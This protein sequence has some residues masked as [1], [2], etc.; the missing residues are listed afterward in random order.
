M[1]ALDDGRNLIIVV[2]LPERVA[3]C[4]GHHVFPIPLV[5]TVVYPN[6]HILGIRPSMKHVEV[7]IEGQVVDSSPRGSAFDQPM[8]AQVVLCASNLVQADGNGT[9]FLSAARAPFWSALEE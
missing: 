4:S 9:D 3:R 6:E 1:V 5:V 7:V 2:S 8:E